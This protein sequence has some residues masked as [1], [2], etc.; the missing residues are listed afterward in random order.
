MNA[1]TW[2][3]GVQNPLW[4]IGCSEGPGELSAPWELPGTQLPAGPE[5][6]TSLPS[7]HGGAAQSQSNVRVEQCEGRAM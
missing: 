1:A 2:W 6:G 5:E 7:A 3:G 4:C